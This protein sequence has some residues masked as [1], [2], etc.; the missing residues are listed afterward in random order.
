MAR[1]CVWEPVTETDFPPCHVPKE[2]GG[3]T[4][5]KTAMLP[6]GIRH[7]NLTRLSKRPTHG[8]V[9][10]HRLSSRSRYRKV[11]LKPEDIHSPVE[12]LVTTSAKEFSLFGHDIDLLNLQVSVS[13]TDM[14]RMTIRD[15]QHRRYEVPVPIHWQPS[16]KK[17]VSPKMKFQLTENMYRQVGFRIQR[18]DT[19]AILFDTS[20]FASGFIYDD[21]FLQIMTTIPSRNVYGMTNKLSSIRE[22]RS[23]I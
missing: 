9:S 13:G 6:N 5:N 1:G 21:K 8:R 14:I 12:D 2:K 23:I 3:Y 20:F 11:Q 22:R 7:Y 4:L 18:T 19:E 16:S 17:P 15:P 10:H